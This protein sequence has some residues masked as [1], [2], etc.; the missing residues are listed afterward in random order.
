MPPLP[1]PALDLTA[2]SLQKT[3]SII[4]A[5][6]PNPL[7]HSQKP[8]ITPPATRTTPHKHYMSGT[9]PTQFGPSP[10]PSRTLFTLFNQVSLE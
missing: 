5:P 2:L 7:E 4:L 1:D 6:P 9:P 8:E 10:F 3:Q